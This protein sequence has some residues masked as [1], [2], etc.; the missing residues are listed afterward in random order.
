MVHCVVVLFRNQSVSKATGVENRVTKGHKSPKFSLD[1]RRQI[2]YFF[3]F[4]K[5]N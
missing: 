1:F 3:I 5:I 2:S 4:V